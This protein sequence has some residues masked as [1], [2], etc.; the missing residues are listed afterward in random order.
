[1]TAA[2][3]PRQVIDAHWTNAAAHLTAAHPEYLRE[4][5][6]A[7]AGRAISDD[8][9]AALIAAQLDMIRETATR[10]HR[11]GVAHLLTIDARSITELTT[12]E[13]P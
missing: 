7:L 9:W 11:E 1:M 2:P 12:T 8:W 5:L 3:T 4:Q 13:A 10:L 6:E